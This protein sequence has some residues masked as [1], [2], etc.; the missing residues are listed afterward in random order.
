MPWQ[1]VF[2][3]G[4][5][6]QLIEVYYQMHCPA[7]FGNSA[8]ADQC[9]HIN[10]CCV[11]KHPNALINLHRH[12]QGLQLLTTPTTANWISNLSSSPSPGLSHCTHTL[13]VCVRTLGLG[14]THTTQHSCRIV[15]ICALDG[16]A[17]ILNVGPLALSLVVACKQQQTAQPSR[18]EASEEQQHR[19]MGL[20]RRCRHR[21]QLAVLLRH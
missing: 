4:K 16:I 1:T 18:R 12:H 11:V 9:A 6:H 17:S 8:T 7:A 14:T 5:L 19:P 10:A 20:Q 15:S 21:L 3:L 2:H 13:R